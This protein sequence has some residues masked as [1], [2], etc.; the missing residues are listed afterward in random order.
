[1]YK[2]RVVRD[3]NIRQQESAPDLE[4]DSGSG[5]LPKFNGDFP[6]QGHIYDKIF[7]KIRSCSPEI[8]ATLWKNAVCRNVEESFKKIPGGNSSGGI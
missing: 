7:E 6:A 1:M 2:T 3:C 8:Y 4:Q 5:L